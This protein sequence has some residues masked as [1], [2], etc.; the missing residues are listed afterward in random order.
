MQID[1]KLIEYLYF[2]ARI[3]P[4]YTEEKERL[5]QDLSKILSYVEMLNKVDVS[6]IEPLVHSVENKDNIW[7]EDRTGESSGVERALMNA[8]EKHGS[9]FKVP[10]VIE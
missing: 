2:L 6:N 8:P 4:A 7:R 1:D 3:S 10:R 5:K 9:F